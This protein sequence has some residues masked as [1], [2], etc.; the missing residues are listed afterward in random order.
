MANKATDVGSGT[1]EEAATK[2]GSVPV[3]AEFQ[4]VAPVFEKA[5]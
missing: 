5:A 1:A 3:H 4:S 2:T